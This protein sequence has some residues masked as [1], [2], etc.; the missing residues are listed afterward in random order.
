MS[1]KLV[2]L[3]IRKFGIFVLVSNR[4]AYWSNYL[5]RFEI[6][7]IRTSLLKNRLIDWLT[8]VTVLA[9]DARFVSTEGVVVS[10][11]P[12]P[13][14]HQ[15]PAGRGRGD[16]RDGADVLPAAAAGLH[17]EH[18]WWYARYLPLSIVLMIK[19][20]KVKRYSSLS[21]SCIQLTPTGRDRPY[22]ITQF[23]RYPTQVNTPC[24]TQPEGWYLINLL[25]WMEAWVG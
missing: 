21:P 10:R 13:A 7:N 19:R 22:G 23:Y 1:K 8:Q 2:T 11:E 6:S 20:L 12:S 17:W 18:G 24:L 5:I 15:L 3:S 9:D 25:Q 16:R 14:S 4:I